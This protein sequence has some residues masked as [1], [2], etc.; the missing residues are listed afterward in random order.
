MEL[1]KD[2]P[3]L[4]AGRKYGWSVTLVCNPRRPSANPYFYSWIE[5]VAATPALDQQ[6][7]AATLPSGN[8]SPETLRK[9]ALIYAQAGLW[10]NSLADISTAVTANPNNSSVQEDFLDLLAQVGLTEVAKQEQ[11]RLAKN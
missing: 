10:Y 3:E 8:A 2:L 6:L 7:T 5:R 9:R 1:P 4:V 11:Q